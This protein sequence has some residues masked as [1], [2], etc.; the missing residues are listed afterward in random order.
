MVVDD[1][2]QAANR[3][4]MRVVAASRPLCDEN[5]DCAAKWQAAQLWIVQ[6]ALPFQGLYVSSTT[7][8]TV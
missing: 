7:S 8:V 1:A 6:N 5:T 3:E 2:T 4:K